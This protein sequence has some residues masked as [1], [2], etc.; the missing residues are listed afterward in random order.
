LSLPLYYLYLGD[1]K[2]KKHHEADY[3]LLLFY[4]TIMIDSVIHGGHVWI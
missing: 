3:I 4:G 2:K 1:L